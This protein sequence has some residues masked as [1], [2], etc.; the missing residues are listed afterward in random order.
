MK[1]SEAANLSVRPPLRGDSEEADFL[2]EYKLAGDGERI[3]ASEFGFGGCQIERVKRKLSLPKIIA[4]NSTLG[5]LVRSQP[6]ILV[7]V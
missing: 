6:F 7:R 1:R 5:A 3:C 4:A 2:Y